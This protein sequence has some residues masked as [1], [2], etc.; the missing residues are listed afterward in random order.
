M[1]FAGGPE[2][3]VVKSISGFTDTNGNNL[4]DAGD[5]VDFD[6]TVENTG[7]VALANVTIDDVG[8]P[9]VTVT[10]AA[11]F[12]GDLA[13]GEGP[14][15]A[16]TA[17]YTLTAADIA[18]GG[19][20]NSATGTGTPVATDPV[21]GDPI[22]GTPALGANGDPL[23]DTTDVSDAGTEPEIDPTTGLPIEVNDPA[24][25]ETANVDGSSVDTDAGND[26]TALIIPAPA[27]EVVKSVSEVVDTNNNGFTDEGDEL[28]FT[29]EVSNTGNTTLTNIIVA[30]PLVGLTITGSP[31]A[32]IAVGA[33][34]DTSVTGSYFLTADDIAAGGL[35]NTATATGT[36][37][38]ENG[39][40]YPNPFE[41]GQPLTVSD[42]S[43]AGTDPDG[44]DVASEGLVETEDFAGNTDGDPTNDPTVFRVVPMPDITIVKSLADV[45]DVDGSGSINAGDLANYT[46]VVTNT[47]N[48][49]LADVTVTDDLVEVSGGPISLAIG[50]TDT[51]TFTASYEITDADVAAG[52]VENTAVVG[53]V[54][55]AADGTPL[56]DPIT[57][58]TLTASDDSDTG[59]TPDLDENG[60][61]IVQNAADTTE[62]A[63][64]DGST[65]TDPTNDPTVLFIPNPELT[66]VKSLSNVFDD[67]LPAPDGLFGGEGDT[68]AYTFTVTNTGNVDLSG[69]TVTD[70]TADV[71]GGP[72]PL[73][74]VGVGD[75]ITFTATYTITPADFAAGF[76]ENTAEATGAAVDAN[77]DPI[78]GPGGEELIATDTSDTGTTPEGDT[79]DDPAGEETETFDAATQPDGD[80]TNDPTVV[81]LPANP[82]PRVS[83][84]KS[85]ASVADTNGDGLLGEGDTVTYS[86][87]VTNTGNVRLGDV[88]VTDNLAVVSGGPI[89]LE[90]EETDTT[91]F[92]ATSVITADQA[93]NGATE[94]SASADAIGVN[95][96]GEPLIDPATGLPHT[97]TD[98]S[99]AGTEP[100]I[101][102]DDGI[103]AY[104]DPAGNETPDASGATDTDPTNDPTVLF[105]PMPEI[106]VVKS[107][108]SVTDTNGNGFTD[109]GDVVN[110]T[111]SVENTGNTDLVDVVITDGLA[112]VVVTGNP[113]ATLA[114]GETNATQVTATY[115]L[116]AANII[117]GGVENSASGE[118]VAVGA[119]GDVLADPFNPGQPLTVTDTSDAGTTPDG[120]AIDAPEGTETEDFAGGT[121]TDPGNDPTVLLLQPEPLIDV[122]KSITGFIDAVPPAAGESAFL[123][124]GDSVIYSFTVTNVGNVALDDV[125]VFDPLGT[126][127]GGT[128][129]LAIGESNSSAFEM[130]YEL[131]AA[132]IAAGG[133]ENTATAVGDAVDA[134]GDPIVDPRTNRPF[135]TSDVSDAG[136]EPE[137]DA[138][139]D[140]IVVTDPET[141]ETPDI[142]GA[143]DTDPTNDPTVLLLPQ[144]EITLVKVAS[145]V[146]DTNNDGLFGGEDDEVIYAFTVTNTG[147]VDLQ[148]VQIIDDTAVVTGGPIDLAVGDSD[149]VTFTATYIVTAD[150]VA[151]GFVEN[152]ATATGDAVNANGD[153]LID[154]NG[155]PISTSDVSDTGSNPDVSAVDDPENTE[156]AD[157][158]G[159]TDGD[160]TNDPTVTV[161]PSNPLPRI[162]VVKSIAS[163]TDNGDGVIGEGD[164]VNY[165]FTVTNTGNI[166]LADVA[167]EDDLVAVSG[168]PISL[169]LGEQ[170][171]TEFTAQYTLTAADV[172]AGGV[173][174]TAT[175]TGT[176]VNS[177]GDPITEPNGGPQLTTSDVSDAGSEPQPTATGLIETID[178]PAGNETPDLAGDTDTDSTNDPTVLFIPTP[179]IEV[180][181]SI[182]SAPDSNRDGTFGGIG[183]TLFYSFTVTNTGNV[184]LSD[185]TL[186][187]PTADVVGGPIPLLEVGGVDTAT[188]TATYVVTANDVNVVGYVENTATAQGTATGSDGEPIGDPANPGAPMVA[189]D[190]SDTGTDPAGDLISDAANT[191]TPDGEGVTDGDSTNDPTVFTVPAIPQPSIQIIKSVANVFDTDGDNVLGGEDDE[192]IYSFA[193]TNTGDAALVDVTVN[194]PMLGGLVAT[195]PTLAVL[196]TATVTESYIITPENQIDGFIENQAT[197][198]GTAVNAQGTPLLDPA[199]GEPL[200]P[201]DV[202]DTGTDQSAEGIDDPENVETGDF[203]GVTDGDATNDPTILSVPLAVP[204][205]A[206]SGMVFFDE[207]DDGVFN[208]DD[209]PL[210]GFVVNL[211]DADGNIIATT[212]TDAAGNYLMEGFPTGEGFQI[213]FFDPITGDEV[214]D[215]IT[216]LTFGPNT[217]LSDQDGDI[218]AAPDPGR[219]VLTKSTDLTT[220]IVGTSVPY[221]IEA[222]NLSGLQVTTDII[223]LLP[224]GMTYTPGSGLIDGVAVEPTI[225][226]QTLTWSEVVVP[227]G[228]TV[229]LELVTRVGANAPIGDLTNTVTVVD[230]QTGDLL[231]EPATATVRRVPEAVFDCSDIIGK[232]FDDRNFNGYQDPARDVDARLSTRSG[233]ITNQSYY[234]GKFAGLA[235]QIPAAEE[236]EPGLPNVRLVTPNGTIITTDEYGRYSVPC[237]ALPDDIGSNFTLKLDPRSLPTGYRVTT[238]NPRTMRVTAGIATEMNFG[239]ALGRVLDIDLTAAAF[240]GDQPVDRL[241]QGVTQLLRQVV[242][243]P[244]V[245]RI[246]YFTNGEDSQ[247]ALRRIAELENLIDR[248]WRDIGRYRL[249]VE[250]QVLRLQ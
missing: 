55:V 161:I 212:L 9:N 7:T 58:E 194:D 136:T 20:E 156:T 116:T 135:T 141:V 54:A 166:A 95:S 26:P 61:P 11:T 27:V 126:V 74:E 203:D 138:N 111:F 15:A 69:V 234:G 149:S 46:F 199:T 247:T 71:S 28:R 208:G 224:V 134:N 19:I 180:V 78:Y 184:D 52:G 233:A 222:E 132:D 53:S 201:S 30:D 93:A 38:D 81:A 211:L 206:V 59:T 37:V 89:S 242:D 179:S 151:N 197:T 122:V 36:A 84:V 243:T 85:V 172:A 100:E 13:V 68:I 205:T 62:T 216:G 226:G 45:V 130:V 162:E 188:F 181:K 248:R 193:V 16:A 150:D 57:G 128:I 250:T 196:E 39:D 65:D 209:F 2:L 83:I 18:A 112:G 44:D 114:Q 35:Q 22:P 182:A 165:V 66:V 47:G 63:G 113:I 200:V 229:K 207:N 154:I 213:A 110:Y 137:L 214:G 34:A 94:N 245:I 168:G 91:T 107:V 176:A 221:E 118:A 148:N 25:E 236:G 123:E 87:A 97:A 6:F 115:A 237:A 119:D 246:S 169:A 42:V 56:V 129:S 72:I 239:A 195:I 67:N 175:A 189:T 50:A 225:A 146:L 49:A 108:A 173:E 238:E 103:V 82:T 17:Q 241:D 218:T 124:A 88:T 204:D 140:P 40:A 77:G 183:D 160:P 244:S 96:L 101:T 131:T 232:V 231:A 202:S 92:T 1:T 60:D 177:N 157:A 145:N 121:D 217:V 153:P 228:T 152:T 155:N 80:L 12:D 170:N 21:S 143:T 159:V 41:T 230:A 125:D 31:I 235:E 109:E 139:G 5:I 73:L 127:T 240:N 106:A 167:I 171:S 8:L 220:V 133:I 117:A 174:N 75:S 23:P 227:A 144:P 86:F 33:S 98:V 187:D 105:L 99:D 186:L 102:Q 147:N 10:P 64:L 43:D 219:L 104:S 178:D 90:I 14:I 191:E 215:R 190:T 223:D 142:I 24:S 70:L 79:V 185:V 4:L 29:F 192:V 51:T 120:E 32:S 198:Q 210:E 249:I 163:V 3:V 164:L 76:V 48:T 158:A